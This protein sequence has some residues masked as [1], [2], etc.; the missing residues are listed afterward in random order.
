MIDMVIDLMSSESHDRIMRHAVLS[1]EGLEVP[2]T[3]R[4]CV[5]GRTEESLYQGVHP[6]Y[7]V[8]TVYSVLSS[9]QV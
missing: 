2:G 6:I 5:L 9:I 1:R 3:S 8:Y 4:H 7:C